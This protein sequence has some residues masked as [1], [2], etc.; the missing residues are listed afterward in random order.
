MAAIPAVAEAIA[1]LETYTK[2]AG[3]PTFDLIADAAAAVE[4]SRPD[5]VVG[6]GGGSALDLAKAARLV[7][8]QGQPFERF[9]DG[10]V[11][12]EPPAVDLV[13]VP[14]TSGTGSEVSGGAVVVIRSSAASAASPT[15]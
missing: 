9:C 11:A 8:G 5:V 14:T 3:E 15:R 7:A 1:G 2:A 13:A 12:V 10:E 4:R 6:I